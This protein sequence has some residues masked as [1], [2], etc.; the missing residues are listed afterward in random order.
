MA[1]TINNDY[2]KMIY[3]Q[4]SGKMMECINPYVDTWI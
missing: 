1:L 3:F 2:N 4:S